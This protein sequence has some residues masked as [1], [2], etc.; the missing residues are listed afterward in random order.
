M[1]LAGF[2]PRGHRHGDGVYAF[3]VRDPLPGL[4]VYLCPPGSE[5]HQN[6]MRFRDILR[7]NP[8]LANDYATL[9]MM[10]AETYEHDDDA[11]TRAQSASFVRR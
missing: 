1:E 7:Q 10:L 2:E 11:Y 4:R 8:S 9:K 6:R 5:T 3:M